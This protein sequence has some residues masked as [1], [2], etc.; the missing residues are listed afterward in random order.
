MLWARAVPEREARSRSGRRG[1]MIKDEEGTE[2][3][4]LI[5]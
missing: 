2:G 1:S 3:R 4:C 5:F